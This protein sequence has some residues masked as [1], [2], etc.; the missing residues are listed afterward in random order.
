VNPIYLVTVSV[1]S[2]TLFAA[3]IETVA[4]PRPSVEYPVTVT[5][6]PTKFN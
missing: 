4:I 2:L 1:G 5:P 6:G 3:K